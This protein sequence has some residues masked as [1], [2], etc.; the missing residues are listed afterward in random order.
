MWV[1]ARQVRGILRRMWVGR[2][3][4]V[5]AGVLGALVGCA[6]IFGDDDTPSGIEPAD[7]GTNDAPSDPIGPAA[8]ASPDASA[9]PSCSGA[10]LPC[11]AQ[12]SCCETKPVP[13]GS[14]YRSYDGVPDGGYEDR[15]FPATV[16]PFYL[17][18]F[19]VVVAR[20]RAFVAAGKG[21][22]AGAPPLGAGTAPGLPA[23]GWTAA[24]TASL[25]KDET[26]LRA[27][28]ATA[29]NAAQSMQCTWSDG[30]GGKEHV[31]IGCVTWYE[32]FAF[33]IWDGG[34]LPTE[35]EWN[36]AA[37]GGTD[38]RAYAWSNPSTDR[39][40]NATLSSYGSD[41]GAP[42]LVGSKSPLGDG[43]FGHA[44]LTGNV[45]EWIFDAHAAYPVPCVGSCVVASGLGRQIRGGSVTDP[46]AKLL[47]SYRAG[48]IE[49]SRRAP[50][51]GFR[52]AHDAL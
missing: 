30:D 20:F 31:A 23:T 27:K 9:R 47:V 1:C 19:E 4:F 38:Q 22:K 11:T 40:I 37:A 52:C 33:C 7:S 12:A 35:A 15:G 43:R 39:T 18:T 6:A 3:A 36:Y 50:G 45:S 48:Y 25:E 44:D 42:E 29:T 32:A 28:L 21:T 10:P 8:D 5:I 24:Y 13:G 51:T 46:P 17:D 16:L 2:S 14:F 41:G 49:P 26:T 34:R